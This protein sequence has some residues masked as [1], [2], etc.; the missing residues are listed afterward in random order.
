MNFEERLDPQ[1]AAV[2]DTFPRLDLSDFVGA[3]AERDAL[4]ARMRAERPRNPEVEIDDRLIAREDEPP[5]RARLYR[6]KRGCTLPALIWMHRG[7]HVIGSI[8]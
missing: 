1:I 2:L 6:L 4:A 8:D 7:G 5:V 3:R